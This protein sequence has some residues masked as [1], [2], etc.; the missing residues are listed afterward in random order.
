MAQKLF[1]EW[2][3]DKA[4]EGTLGG[5]WENI[6]HGGYG[7]QTARP[8][9]PKPDIY[10]ARETLK[11]CMANMRDDPSRW[12]S[13]GFRVALEKV[14]GNPQ[15]ERIIGDMQN[16]A[17][18]FYN[19]IRPYGI[20]DQRQ[21]N[22]IRPRMPDKGERGFDEYQRLYLAYYDRLHNIWQ[23]LDRLSTQS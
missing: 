12:L 7:G 18:Q 20:Y 9:A 19:A 11:N 23:Q 10:S 14:R 5:A 1:M 4:N 22:T 15:A 16:V 13:E 2:L 17:G 21:G 8:E 3:Q 6:P